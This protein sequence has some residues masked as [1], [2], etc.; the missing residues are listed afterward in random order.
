MQSFDL[1]DF[2]KN[3]NDHIRCLKLLTDSAPDFLTHCF[4]PY[5]W[6]ILL[7]IHEDC[8]MFIFLHV[9]CCS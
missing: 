4:Q 7:T 2:I 8:A 3:L 6:S 5:C 9:L 1:K